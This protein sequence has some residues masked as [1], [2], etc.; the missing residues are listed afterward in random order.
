MPPTWRSSATHLVHGTQQPGL[1]SFLLGPLDSF[2]P[3]SAQR[4]KSGGGGGLRVDALCVLFA[5]QAPHYC[6][7]V[8]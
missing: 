2:R 4:E 5:E 6:T 3:I 8:G 1:D 7:A